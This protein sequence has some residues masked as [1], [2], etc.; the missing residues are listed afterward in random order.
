[1][2]TEPH[3][4]VEDSIIKEDRI[5]SGSVFTWW[6]TSV[7]ISVVSW[8]SHCQ[9]TCQGS[10]E[11][12]TQPFLTAASRAGYRPPLSQSVPIAR[13]EKW[14]S[15]PSQHRIFPWLHACGVPSHTSGSPKAIFWVARSSVLPCQETVSDPARSRARLHQP[16]HHAPDAITG[17]VGACSHKVS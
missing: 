5:Y 8:Q 10:N 9:Q 1:M 16:L 2:Q 3:F 17:T 15:L 6:N 7:H 13:R 11:T 14:F 4:T 12:G